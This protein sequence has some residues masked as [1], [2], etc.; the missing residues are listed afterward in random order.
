MNNNL[1]DAISA[2]VAKGELS[3]RYLLVGSVFSIKRRRVLHP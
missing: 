1:F 3:E 2:E